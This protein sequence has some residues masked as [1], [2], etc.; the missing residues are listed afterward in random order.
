MAKK[1][2]VICGD[3][4][5]VINAFQLHDTHGIPL[6]AVFDRGLEPDLDRFRTDAQKAGWSERHIEGVIADALTYRHDLG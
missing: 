5:R 1:L 3:Y 4:G 2:K 6:W